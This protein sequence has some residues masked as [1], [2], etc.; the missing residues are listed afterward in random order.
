MGIIVNKKHVSLDVAQ[1]LTD[2]CPFGAIEYQDGELS[3]NAA[4]KSCRLCVKKG[5]QDVMIWQDEEAKSS[6][7]KSLWRGIA[8]FAQCQNCH[9][10]PVTPELIG[11]ARELAAV[12][13][14]KVLAIIIGNDLAQPVEEL[15]SYGVDEVYSYDHPGFEHF[16]ISAYSNAFYDFIERRKPGSIFVGATNLGRSLAPRV[17]ARC[18]TGLT[19][20][21]TVLK[22]KEK[23][24][25]TKGGNF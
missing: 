22:M 15:L 14:E 10:H 5:P 2:L 9:L 11:K 4:C 7:D 12:I 20:D 17:A 18:H 16:T 6:L 19:A 3:I 25:N 23:F 24:E 21:C 13:G 1:K 8:V